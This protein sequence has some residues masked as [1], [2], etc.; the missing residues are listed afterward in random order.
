LKLK[1]MIT[2]KRKTGQHSKKMKTRADCGYWHIY[3]K[4]CKLRMSYMKK[5]K[6]A[7]VKYFFL[8]I[9]LNSNDGKN[10][11][12]WITKKREGHK[13][14]GLEIV[15]VDWRNMG[16]R[17]NPEGK[18]DKEEDGQNFLNYIDHW[19]MIK[20]KKFWAIW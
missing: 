3:D 11:E 18:F 12:D 13:F 14:N 19:K 17:W 20:D 4:T 2:S 8:D 5:Q 7:R 1:K 16:G 10:V 6:N 9:I 15:D